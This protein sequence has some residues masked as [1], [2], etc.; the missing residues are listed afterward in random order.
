MIKRI[1][2][3]GITIYAR[4]N[5]NHMYDNGCNTTFRVKS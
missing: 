3:H 5:C 4:E 2:N 1:L